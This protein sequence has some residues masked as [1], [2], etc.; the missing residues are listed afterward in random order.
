MSVDELRAW[1]AL[2]DGS[3]FAR[4][5]DLPDLARFMLATGLRLGEALG[6][7]WPDVDLVAGTLAVRRTIVRVN[8][9]GDVPRSGVT[10]GLVP[11]R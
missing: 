8:G 9:Q 6:V 3:P 2:L 7:T 10:P 1:L 5:H 4:R 11:E